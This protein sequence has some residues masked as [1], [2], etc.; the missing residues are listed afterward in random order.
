L[1]E[2]GIDKLMQT[3]E[4]MRSALLRSYA[5]SCGKSLKTFRDNLSVPSLGV[6]N[7]P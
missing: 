1:G 4:N 2:G 3:K 5:A 6:K 7:P